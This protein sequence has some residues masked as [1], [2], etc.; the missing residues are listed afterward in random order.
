[1]I[2]YTTRPSGFG[3]P[4][5]DCTGLTSDDKDEYFKNIDVPNGSTFYEIDKEHRVFMYDRTNRQWVEQ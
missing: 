3:Q 1:M 2:T 5:M 4:V